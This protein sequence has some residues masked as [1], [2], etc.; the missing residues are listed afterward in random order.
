MFCA[1]CAAKLQSG[2]IGLSIT[3]YGMVFTVDIISS[4][5]CRV[6]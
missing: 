5:W 6:V 3:W 2:N 4:I 1:E